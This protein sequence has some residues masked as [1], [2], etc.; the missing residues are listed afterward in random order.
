MNPEAY[1]VYQKSAWEW[2]CLT[3]DF[4]KTFDNPIKCPFENSQKKKMD[5]PLNIFLVAGS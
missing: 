1:L 4:L 5:F 2:P 3:V